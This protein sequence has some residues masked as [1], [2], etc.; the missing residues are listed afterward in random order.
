MSNKNYKQKTIHSATLSLFGVLTLVSQTL[1][2]AGPQVPSYGISDAIKGAEAPKAPVQPNATPAPLIIQQEDAPMSLGDGEKI[3]IRDFK[4]EGADFLDQTALSDLLE[5]Y[6]NKDLTIDQIDEAANRIT[7]YCRAQ[8]YLVARAYVPKQNVQNGLLLIRVIA[9]QYGKFQMK[10]NSFVKDAS[11]QAI[12]DATKENVSIVNRDGLERSMLLAS[13]MPGAGMPM[14]SISPGTEPG[15]SDFLVETPATDR[16]K[17]YV[18]ADNYGSRFTGKNR[19]SAGVDVNSPFGFGDRLS[20]SGLTSKAAG[21]Q[22]G[23]AAY[24]FPWSASGLR[25]EFSLSRTTYKL[26]DDFADLNAT[27]TANVID[28]TIS[29][30]LRRTRDDSIY[31]S[32]NLAGKRLEDDIAV[33]SS[34]VVKHAKVANVGVRRE[35]YGSLFGFNSYA[36]LSGSLTFGRLDFDDDLQ[37]AM[38]QA[39]ANTAG[40]YSKANLTFNGNLSLTQKWALTGMAQVQQALGRN[41]DGSEQ[42]SISGPGG[43]ISYPDGV[44]SDNGYLLGGELKYA[45]PSI[46]SVDQS[47]GFFADYGAVSPQDHS[48]TTTGEIRI[49]DV[50][51]AYYISNKSFFGSLWLAKTMGNQVETATYNH[52]LKLLAQVGMRF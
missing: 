46:G 13:D 37:K 39:G 2:A 21:L 17:G 24:S 49:G 12:F 22:N 18:V 29:Y 43:I 47:V 1:L 34:T 33:V 36:S 28:T 10:N 27:G 45:L 20:L 11:L 51:L 40:N 6:R 30:P 41:L 44:T 4:V 8:G 16:V 25:Q 9:G 38:N 23:R 5:P 3:A 31:L 48:F 35:T 42:M 19:L 14:V 32:M 52:D 50:G 15:T 26:G 7:V